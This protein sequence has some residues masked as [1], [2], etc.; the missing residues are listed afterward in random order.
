[1]SRLVWAASTPWKAT[2][3][4][5][6]RPGYSVGMPVNW[7]PPTQ[8]RFGLARHRRADARHR[9]LD[10]YLLPFVLFPGSYWVSGW[11]SVKIGDFRLTTDWP[12]SIRQPIAEAHGSTSGRFLVIVTKKLMTTR[13]ES[14]K[15][16]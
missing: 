13:E 5:V 11:V 3:G 7:T 8:G 9:R 4:A 6:N 15:K 14:V 12:I 1:M 16:S 2:G 10:A